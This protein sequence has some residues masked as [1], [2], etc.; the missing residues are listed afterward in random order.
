MHRRLPVRIATTRAAGN[1][2]SVPGLWSL[3]VVC[4]GRCWSL[5]V[6]VGGGWRGA[7]IDEGAVPLRRLEFNVAEVAPF[8]YRVEDQLKSITRVRALN[9]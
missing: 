9:D 6:V 2:D 5:V 8:R 4:G 7:V 1:M 3:A